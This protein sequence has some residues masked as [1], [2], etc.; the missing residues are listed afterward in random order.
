MRFDGRGWRVGEGS[1]GACSRRCG[2]IKH[3]W[4][5]PLADRAA[6]DTETL[7]T[8]VTA[9]AAEPA[10]V[11]RDGMPVALRRHVCHGK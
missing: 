10:P 8:H 6:P 5:G 7:R 9:S 1:A 4:P 2:A 3:T 11:R